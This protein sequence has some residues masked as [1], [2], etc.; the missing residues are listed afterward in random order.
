MTKLDKN[1][2]KEV[3]LKYLEEKDFRNK[4]PEFILSQRPQMFELLLKEGLVTE[5]MKEAFFYSSENT[6]IIYK[7][8]GII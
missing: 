8:L 7:S 2:I 6:Y 5:D 1:K 3:L 4:P